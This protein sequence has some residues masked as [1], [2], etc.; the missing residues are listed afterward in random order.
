MIIKE[1]PKNNCTAIL[2][3][4]MVIQKNCLNCQIIIE[5]SDLLYTFF[6]FCKS[7]DEEMFYTYEEAYTQL[8]NLLN[9]Y[10]HSTA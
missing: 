10:S 4:C 7:L 9:E 1:L 3:I 2:S 5:E 6:D 8:H